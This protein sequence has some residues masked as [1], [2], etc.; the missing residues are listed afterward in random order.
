MR[1]MAWR[2]IRAGDVELVLVNFTLPLME[3]KTIPVYDG[4]VWKKGACDASPDMTWLRVN[5]KRE[6]IPQ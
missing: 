2:E 5:D 4:K 3:Q 1:A 6:G